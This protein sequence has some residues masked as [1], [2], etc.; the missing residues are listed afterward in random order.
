MS[1]ILLF[2]S[3][4]LLVTLFALST[5]E[6]AVMAVDYGTDWFKVALV[7]PG[8]PLDIVLN[9][10]SKR[11]TQ[12]VLT[13][14]GEERIYGTDAVNL[15]ARLPQNTYFTLKK[16]IGRLADDTYSVEYQ[17]TF[18][19]KII[20]G[21]KRGTVEF[22][23]NDT[24]VF[25]VEELL[26]MQLSHAKELAE[27]TAQE[28]IKDAVITVPPYYSQFERQAVL[29]AA[30]LAGLHVLSLI[31]EGTAVGLNYAISHFS[32]FTDEP[33]YHL[34]YDMGAGS[35]KASLISFKTVSVKDVGRFNKTVIN[36][37]VISIGYD[38]TLGG[39]EID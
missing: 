4:L 5:S 11:K 28:A 32:S 1:K 2:Q 19:N 10:D 18:P 9:R 7:K 16:V 38:R 15:G 26:A 13:V 34:F 25:S 37:D 23:H 8:I 24:T 39:K 36:L 31:N 14:R 17:S 30:E 20:P 27:A 22:Q 12:S 6:A 35:T 33:Q 21:P 3:V 29:D